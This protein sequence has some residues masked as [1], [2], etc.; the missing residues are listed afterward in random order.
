MKK[1]D[2]PEYAQRF[3]IKGY[4]VKKVGNVYYQY[5][6]DH[7]RT[8]DKK[9]PITKL[10][11]IGKIDEKKGLVKTHS[12]TDEVIAYLEYGLSNYL[13]TK[14]KRT[15]Q[16]SLFNTNGKYA[17]D[18]IKLGIINYIFNNVN[19]NT[20]KSSYLTYND[21][22]ELLEKYN[23]SSRIKSRIDTLKNKIN[24]ILNS[25]FTDKSDLEIILYSLKNM[26]AVITKSSKRINII[27]STDIKKIFIKYGVEYE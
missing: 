8:P 27:I 25:L 4:D 23:S 6:V 13:F 24:E 18:L 11:Y 22:E 21:V 10:T 12:E 2:L 9:Y 17:E 14:Y 3:K 26:N 5:K 16:R 20:L 19:L 7:Y 15:L 1:T